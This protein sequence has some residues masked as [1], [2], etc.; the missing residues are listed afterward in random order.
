MSCSVGIHPR[1]S[2]STWKKVCI[3][4]SKIT[5]ITWPVGYESSR[6]LVLDYSADRVFKNISDIESKIS[7]R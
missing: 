5:S 6:N 2:K 1:S 7:R 3:L 4:N